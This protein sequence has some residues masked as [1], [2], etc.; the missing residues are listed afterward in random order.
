MKTALIN[1]WILSMDD[2]FNEYNPGYIIIEDD[3]ILD[4]GHLDDFKNDGIESIIDVNENII[5]PGM[6][7]AHT[8]VGMIPFR[9]LGDDMKDRL[10]KLLFPLEE[11]LSE[12]LVR[13]SA[14]YA[15]AEMLLAGITT[16]ADMYYFENAIAEEVDKM[17]MRAL[18]GETILNIPTCDGDGQPYYGLTYAKNY[19]PKWKN[20][21][22]IKPMLAPHATNTNSKHILEEIKTVSKTNGVPIMMHVSEMDYEID[23]F[24]KEYNLTPVEFLNAI[25]L[26]SNDFLAV[27]C[28]H[29]SQNDIKLL[30]K[31][32][33]NVIH[34]IDANMKSAKGIMPLKE[35]L[36]ADIT[37]GLGTDGPSSGNTL[38]LFTVMKTIAYA[39]KTYNRDRSIFPS[40]EIFYL[41]TRGG[42]KAIREDNHI[43][44]LKAN[45]QA[46]IVVIERESVNMFPIFDPYSALVYSANSSNVKD[47]W[48]AGVQLVK[49][50]QLV[51]RDLQTIR[52][53]LDLE[54][55]SYRKKVS[56]LQNNK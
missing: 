2:D 32:D 40:R 44:Q 20:H 7:N 11:N 13:A 25:G 22:L 34:C 39:Q 33:V 29:L 6:I 27:H 15:M 10:R 21:P 3:T 49:N 12:E 26:L 1:G 9:S 4:I 46:D 35:V 28:I 47:V 30:K 36:E 8:H 24:K 51:R 23:Y 5:I 18:L 38:D 31:H 56:E 41:A 54:M 37:V 45:Y 52:N 17:G 42:A 43:G 50:K 55:N 16:F 53:N 48:V 19:I 14:N